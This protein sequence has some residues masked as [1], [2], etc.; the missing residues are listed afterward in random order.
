MLQAAVELAKVED[1][2]TR[3]A[4]D[5]QQARARLATANPIRPRPTMPRRRPA[6]GKPRC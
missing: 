2:A 5:E 3:I 6:T 4:Q 1:R